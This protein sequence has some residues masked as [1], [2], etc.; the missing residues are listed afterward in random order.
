MLEISCHGS[1]LIKLGHSCKIVFF[2]FRIPEDDKLKSED[3]DEDAQPGRY[4]VE[5]T[6]DSDV[7]C[8][9]KIFYFATE[10]IANG[11]LR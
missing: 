1:N 4:N 9:V 10:E 11:H 5:F 3:N 8:N 2:M 6:L 7:K